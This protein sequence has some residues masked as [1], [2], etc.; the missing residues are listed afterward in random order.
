MFSLKGLI[1]IT[2]GKR[3]A[4]YGKSNR[5]EFRLTRSWAKPKAALV[6]RCSAF[7]AVV[8][9]LFRFSADNAALACGYENW[10][11]QAFSTDYLIL[12][13]AFKISPLLINSVQEA[14]IGDK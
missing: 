9:G 13:A 11:F 4:T 8:N 1:F 12:P 6:L 3:S 7:Q 10:A 2:V 14:I 5:Y